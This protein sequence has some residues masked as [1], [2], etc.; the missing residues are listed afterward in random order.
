M[1]HCNQVSRALSDAQD[2]KLP[3]YQLAL[4]RFHLWHCRACR[5]LSESLA[6]TR[7]MLAKMLNEPAVDQLSD[8]P[9]S[10]GHP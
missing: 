1:L 4:I 3:R 2:G 6:H 10:D 7:S 5:A 9:H 8:D